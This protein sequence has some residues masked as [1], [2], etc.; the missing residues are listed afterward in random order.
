MNSP[1]IRDLEKNNISKETDLDNSDHDSH[2]INSMTTE[3]SDAGNVDFIELEA[4]KDDSVFSSSSDDESMAQDDDA[5]NDDDDD[6]DTDDDSQ[7]SLVDFVVP[8]HVELTSVQSR[9]RKFTLSDDEREVAMQTPL[10]VF[11]K[12]LA[13]L[14]AK[15]IV[16]AVV[17]LEKQYKKEKE[18]WEK[19]WQ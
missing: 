1:F 15:Q 11:G 5:N 2:S 8:D 17:D 12:R 3:S 13:H 18:A 16:E 9:K 19:K 10:P 7:G 6:I 14:K 4:E